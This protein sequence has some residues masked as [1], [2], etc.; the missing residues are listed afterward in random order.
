M[1][2]SSFFIVLKNLGF[3]TISLPIPE[4]VLAAYNAKVDTDA[5]PL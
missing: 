3:T 4:Y 5:T 2:G 1:G